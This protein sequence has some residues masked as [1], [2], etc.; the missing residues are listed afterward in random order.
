MSKS[1]D[2]G[3]V[4]CKSLRITNQPQTDYILACKDTTGAVYWSPVSSGGGVSGVGATSPL[5]SSGGA[6]PVISLAGTVAVANGGTNSSLPLVNNRAM[7]SSG[8]AV[9][10]STITATELDYLDNVTSNIQAQLNTISANTT[11]KLNTNFSNLPA[12]TTLPPQ[13]TTFD[14]NNQNLFFTGGA[15]GAQ[16]FRT[17]FRTL[18]QT[19]GGVNYAEIGSTVNGLQI[20]A[21][22]VLTIGAS[23]LSDTGGT[24]IVSSPASVQQFRTPFEQ[25]FANAAGSQVFARIG[26]AVSPPGLNVPPSSTLSLGTAPDTVDFDNLIN[27]L[28]VVNKSAATS[29]QVYRCNGRCLYQDATG[30]QTYAEIGASVNGV[31]VPAGKTFTYETTNGDFRVLQTTDSLGAAAWG[32]RVRSGVMGIPPDLLC[33]NGTYTNFIGT[34]IRI[35]KTVH[36]SY[37]ITNDPTGGSSGGKDNVR[38]SAIYLPFGVYGILSSGGRIGGGMSMGTSTSS[39]VSISSP[40]IQNPFIYLDL[41]V[42]RLNHFWNWIGSAAD[43][44]ELYV[45]LTYDI[46]TDAV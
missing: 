42:S 25:Q 45:N 5:S 31:K 12:L 20:P 34:F 18:Y 35:G 33:S 30:T 6:M 2:T 26:A 10:E 44:I 21:P 32:P 11:N 3:Q 7:I 28:Y 37:S 14:H 39:E 23:V 16:V 22:R 1:I 41:G 27:D 36:V 13:T 17:D 4:V 46:I 38:F 9:V 8:G 24:L 29:S 43:V 15:T 19:M 40:S